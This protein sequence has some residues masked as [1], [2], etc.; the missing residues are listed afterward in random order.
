MLGTVFP[1]AV[2]GK[3]KSRHYK[4]KRCNKFKA[5]K[6]IFS[7]CVTFKTL[8]FR[9]TITAVKSP[10][11]VLVMSTPMKSSILEFKTSLS[12][13]TFAPTRLINWKMNWKTLIVF[14][15]KTDPRKFSFDPLVLA[16]LLLVKLTFGSRLKQFV[17][18]YYHRV[19]L[20]PQ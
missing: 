9:F 8:F 15:G 13:S 17:Q 6:T 14:S 7:G 1:N 19:S 11:S 12:D 18:Y 10:N 5:Q 2:I 3:H 16:L 4:N 20:R